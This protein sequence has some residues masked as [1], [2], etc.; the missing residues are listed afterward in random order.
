MSLLINF[1]NQIGAGPKNISLNFIQNLLGREDNRTIFII[2]PNIEEYVDLE[3]ENNIQFIKFK[4]YTNILS[5]IIFRIYLD[6]IFIP[7]FISKNNIKSLLA[8]GNYLISPSKIKKIILLHH[9]YLVDNELINRLN[10]KSKFIEK[11]KRFVFWLTLKNVDTLVI[12]SK[13]MK[14]SLIAT[15]GD[16]VN[17]TIIPNPISNKFS[18]QYSQ[19][20]IENL[21][22]FRFQ[23]IKDKITIF[24]VS[25]FY[26]HKNHDF[27]IELSK[28]LNEN[29]INHEILITID[30]HNRETLNFQKELND[31]TS[32]LN[33]GEIDQTELASYYEK[34]H[35]FIFPSNSETFGNPL[36]EAMKFA[37][38]IIVPDLQYAHSVVEEAG[39]YYHP[40]NHEECSK[41]INSLIIDEKYYSYKSLESYKQFVNYP[42][43]DEWVNK[44]FNLLEKKKND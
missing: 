37:L 39:I 35:L 34:S 33:I 32:I 22:N 6:L 41:I 2:V 3:S 7:Y 42:E 11:L 31:K 10:F 30:F 26:P 23:T 18:K 29:N 9:P 21:I 27:L 40:T 5:K 24:Y 17:N 8:F 13:Y 25:R 28:L 15:W 19:V 43:V 36:I 4:R 44:Y 12:Q 20:E 16:K 14:K 38:P 1:Y